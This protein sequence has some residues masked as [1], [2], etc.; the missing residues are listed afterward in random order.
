MLAI[1]FSTDLF[2]SLV[3]P[4]KQ[5]SIEVPH[6]QARTDFYYGDHAL[7]PSVFRE[8]GF[9]SDHALLSGAWSFFMPSILLYS[10]KAVILV[11]QAPRLA[12]RGLIRAATWHSG[13]GT[14]S[15]SVRWNL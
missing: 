6:G 10:G 15:R 4:Q 7:L 14:F 2:A 9:D 11:S 5:P 13:P 12:F 1:T 8:S 3:S